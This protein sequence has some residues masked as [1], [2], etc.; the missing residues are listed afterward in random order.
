MRPLYCGPMGPKW[1]TL[2]G[3]YGVGPKGPYGPPHGEALWGP[4]IRPMGPK[5][6]ANSVFQGVY[7]YQTCIKQTNEKMIYIYIC[8]YIY[9]CRGAS[10][11][12]G[13]DPTRNIWA[14]LGPMLGPFGFIRPMFLPMLGPLGPMLGQCGSI[15]GPCWAHVAHIWAHFD[16][17]GP[18]WAH[19]GQCYAHLGPC[20]GLLRSF[21]TLLDIFWL[22]LGPFGTI[23]DVFWVHSGPMLGLRWVPFRSNN[24]V[25]GV[26][27][28]VGSDTT[29]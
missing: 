8:I 4:F 19:V 17:L 24:I 26:G 23:L 7:P 16:A 1:D 6:P 9:M 18:I 2:V 20:W 21:S 10:G 29:K 28:W 12:V 27:G 5:G 25:C 3:P 11:L 15:L 14:Q 22:L 13:G